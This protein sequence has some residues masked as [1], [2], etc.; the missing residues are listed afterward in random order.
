MFGT[1]FVGATILLQGC[2]WMRSNEPKPQDDGAEAGI[3]P[4]KVSTAQ[5]VMRQVPLSVN[6]T[7]G[8]IA[9][10]VSDVAPETDGQVVA[11]PVNIG[12]FVQEG[13]V[14]ARLDDRDAQ[15][16]LQQALASERQAEAAL[17]QA[18]ERLGL[19]KNGSFNASEVP[20][21]LAARR[22][23]EAAEAQA[24]LAEGNA[25]RH[26]KLVET[27]D[28]ARS[29]YDEASA[30][31]AMA[32]AQAKAALQQYEA[33]INAAR[34]GNQG[35]AVA[36]ASLE[37]ARAQTS[38]ARKAL[39]DTVIKAPFAGHI[40]DRPAAPGE[41]VTPSTKIVTIQRINPIKLGLQL[42]E[43]DAGYARVGAA[44]T[45]VVAAYPQRQ[46]SG[47]VTAINPAVD[48]ASRAVSV[49]ARIDNPDS[50]LRP[51]MFATAQLL[52]PAGEEAVFVP[53]QA[54]IND[55]ATNSS[56][57]YVLEGDV[58]RVRVVQ[59]EGRIGATEDGMVRITFGLSGGETVITNNLDQ[60]FDG[61]KV[62]TANT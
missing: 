34:Q 49:E 31:A 10:E 11:T 52:Q 38:I 3:A 16:R 25:R 21:V 22:Q 4:V 36:Q 8:F 54:V 62:M 33:A 61:A 55:P 57:V 23:Y 40:S 27:G 29:V 7:G 12:D 48:P 46:F 2:G 13:A 51:G 35:V 9:Y 39:S 5:A 14:I 41:H 20:E 59:V 19:G 43:A 44:V 47:H 56:R 53:G 32:R 1:L 37:G 24:R 17:R 15:L 42:P 18:R 30:Q 45:A 50:L 58:A 26:A 28:V 6:A 60:L